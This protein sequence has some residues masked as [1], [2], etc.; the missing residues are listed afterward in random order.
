MA[1]DEKLCFVISPI[2]DPDSA[3][4]KRADQVLKHIVGPAAESCDYTALRADE[5]DTPGMIT[6]Q[7]IQH[8]VNATLVIADL[9]ERNPK[10][11]IH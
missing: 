7:V 10:G 11:L 1:K 2:G 9:T 4:R 3:T 6:S 5:I 8:V